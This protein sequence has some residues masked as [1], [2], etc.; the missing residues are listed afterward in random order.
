MVKCGSDSSF[1]GFLMRR[2]YHAGRSGN[3]EGY[4]EEFRKDGK[5]SVWA[6]KYKK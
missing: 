4:I 6:S 3:W 2:A 1:N 5:L